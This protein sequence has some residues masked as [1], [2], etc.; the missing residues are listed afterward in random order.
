MFFS[1]PASYPQQSAPAQR[2]GSIMELWLTPNWMRCGHRQRKGTRLMSAEQQKKK[3]N[4]LMAARQA[5]L[6]ISNNFLPSLFSLFKGRREE[7][8]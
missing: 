4:G 8:T 1:L 6:R 7:Q 3:I 2:A 5:R